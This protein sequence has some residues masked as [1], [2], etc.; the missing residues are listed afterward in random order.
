M[1]QILLSLIGVIA[2]F[3]VNAQI[4]NWSKSIDG[5]DTQQANDITKDNFGNTYIAATLFG[6][7]DISG[8]P[9]ISTGDEIIASPGSYSGV[10]FMYDE[11]GT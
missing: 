4:Y 1:K 8:N 3:A 7:S 11:N 2:A 6:T 10:V 9:G 5:L